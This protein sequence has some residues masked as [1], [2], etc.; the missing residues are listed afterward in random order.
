MP[1][2]VLWTTAVVAAFFV[3]LWFGMVVLEQSPARSFV[4][5]VATLVLL[6]LGLLV[7]HSAPKD[8]G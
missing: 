3:L 6:S 8:E 2:Q 4:A 7:T 5:S 1:K